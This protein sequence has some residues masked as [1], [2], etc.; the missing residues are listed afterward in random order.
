MS[1][2]LRDEAVC[3]RHWDFSETSQT[4]SLFA[5]EHGLLRGLAKGAKRERGTFSGGIG[6]LTRGRV[7]AIVKP[8]RELATLTEWDL[9]ELFPVLGRSLEAHYAGL[10]FAD[11]THH[12]FSPHD[13]HPAAY[14]ALVRSLRSLDDSEGAAPAATLR[15][16]WTALVEA[17]YRPALDRDAETGEPTNL[18]DAETFG[19]SARHG[20]VVNDS[21]ASDR[22]RVRAETVDLL[23]S[24]DAGADL[25]T[26]DATIVTRANRLLAAYLRAILDRELP[27]MRYLL[28]PLEV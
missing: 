14:D 11:L 20:G 7:L 19:F 2:H 17:G 26:A 9:T 8:S 13:P 5:R 4:V 15:F 25:S 12:L 24:I 27:T 23:R 18:A 16:Q 3:V 6:L 1:S 28:G 22:W 10:Y 21:G